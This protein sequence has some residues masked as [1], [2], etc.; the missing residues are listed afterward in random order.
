[1]ERSVG[2]ERFGGAGSLAQRGE[3]DDKARQRVREP[4]VQAGWRG[5]AFV[6]I[7]GVLFDAFPSGHDEAHG[8]RSEH[9][10]GY[11]EFDP[12]ANAQLYRS[13]KFVCVFKPDGLAVMS[14]AAIGLLDEGDEF[15]LAAEPPARH[16]EEFGLIVVTKSMHVASHDATP[17]A[18]FAA[19]QKRQVGEP[20]VEGV[21]QV[22]HVE[23][24][25]PPRE[26][27]GK[28]LAPAAARKGVDAASSGRFG[29]HAA[30][31]LGARRKVQ[32][33]GGETVEES[34]C[35][36]AFAAGWEHDP[37]AVRQLRREA[38]H[39]FEFAFE[40]IRWREQHHVRR[41]RT[42]EQLVR[43]STHKGVVARSR[44][45]G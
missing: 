30:Q 26:L 6:V 36:G 33:G 25:E 34:F 3:A 2:D 20:R 10:F 24:D 29:D 35:F 21:Q 12:V 27:R 8:R 4:G 38:M 37:S 28:K 14:P 11:A 5:E 1:M 13:G 15:R 39:E 22:G 18:D 9:R 19:N 7:E 16:M 44:K 23:V 45:A 41:R 43:G 31:A 42:C 40:V 32:E 17:S